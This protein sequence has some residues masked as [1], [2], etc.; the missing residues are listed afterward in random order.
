MGRAL[1]TSLAQID[2]G[3]PMSIER[4]TLVWVDNHH[5][6]TRVGVDHFSLVAS[7]QVPEDRSIIEESE[8]HHVLHLLKLGWV[9]LPNLSS[10]VGELLMADR[11]HTLACRVI[12]ISRLQEALTIALSLRVRNPHRLLGIIR[13]G[14]VGP[15]HVHGGQKELSWI[16]ISLACLGELDMARHLG[17]NSV[18]S[19]ETETE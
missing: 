4:I 13:L 18:S 6:E 14:L 17:L 10:L 19:D 2:L 16:R 9:H 8:V 3:H 15:L 5:K 1:I 7:L 11:N 12:Q